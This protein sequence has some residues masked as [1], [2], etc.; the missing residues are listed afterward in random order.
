[1]FVQK[2]ISKQTTEEHSHHQKIRYLTGQESSQSFL[3][4]TLQANLSSVNSEEPVEVRHYLSKTFQLFIK[5]TGSA[6]GWFFSPSIS[7]LSVYSHRRAHK[8]GR[9]S[10][11]GNF[12]RAQICCFVY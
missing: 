10:H 11:P 6:S 5:S 1:M 2:V 9:N 12:Y 7:H 4:S 3:L 8:K